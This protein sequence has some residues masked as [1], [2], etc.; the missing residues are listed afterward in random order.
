MKTKIFKPFY[1]ERDLWI[2]ESNPESS[3]LKEISSIKAG[4][5]RTGNRIIHWLRHAFLWDS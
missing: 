1:I 5:K 2:L 3:Y 4:L